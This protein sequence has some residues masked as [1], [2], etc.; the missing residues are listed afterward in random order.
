MYT[1]DIYK[2][3]DFVCG[4]AADVETSSKRWCNLVF[5]GQCV[6]LCMVY[7]NQGLY[8]L[9]KDMKV[10]LGG[11]CMGDEMGGGYW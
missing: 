8:K 1:A 4:A 9:N 5:V 6:C 2:W 11:V 10:I 3:Q 7:A